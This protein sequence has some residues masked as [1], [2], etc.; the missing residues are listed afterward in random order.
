MPAMPTAREIGIL[1]VVFTP[2]ETAF[3]GRPVD[4]Q[5]LFVIE[6]VGVALI[7]WGILVETTE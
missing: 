1:M 6:A 4:N 3:L 5:S 7:A 2:F